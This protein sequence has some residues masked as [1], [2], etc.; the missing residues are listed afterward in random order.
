M[1]PPNV[2]EPR[3]MH[4]SK[5]E[6]TLDP[7][8]WSAFRRFAHRALDDM[9]SYLET[10]RERPAWQPVPEATRRALEEPL[11]REPQGV[12][13]VY[14]DFLE[15]VLPYPYG[16]IHPRFW[17]WVN[18]TGTP[19]ALVAD[20]LASGMN[21]N[22]A[23]FQ[24]AAT[25][26]ERQVISWL[27]EL[28]GLPAGASGLMVSGGSMA[29]LVGLTVARNSVG[30]DVTADGLHAREPRLVLYGSDQT[31]NSVDKAVGILGLGR[32]ALR[33]IPTTGDFTIDL[34]ALTKRI[35]QDRREGRRPFC[36][37]ATAG[38]VN[39]GAIDDLEAIADLC[40]REGLWLHVDG[41]IGALVAASPSLRPRVAGLERADSVAIDLHKWLYQPMEAGC[42]LVR[43]GETHRAAFHAEADY[44]RPLRG[45]VTA[46]GPNFTDYGPQLSRSFKA[47]KVWMSLK[48][49]G[50]A[51]FGRLIEQNV[52]QARHLADLVEE[53]PALELLAPAPLN[54]VCFR[55]VAPGLDEPSLDDINE[56]LLV[57]L[58]ESGV[59]VPNSTRIRGRFTLRVAITN[60]RTRRSDLDLLVREVLR[61]GD[62]LTAGAGVKEEER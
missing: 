56:R 29:N 12:E 55:Y 37:V 58:Q 44:L 3:G 49:E 27:Q 57:A 28:I 43:D 8:D 15:H 42:V 26:V 24:Q 62:L 32:S 9:L 54:I 17:G 16:N 53:A 41:A 25:Y 10:V 59:A 34:A 5:V 4:S 30:H 39:T 61:L 52:A 35:D 40:I 45:G 51:K 38:T 50:I 1:K 19:L 31:H 2:T 11:P 23:S 33:H 47:L 60:H 14:R 46:R 6:E 36:V 48:A 21:S 22:L 13:A 18:G 7:Q 20:M